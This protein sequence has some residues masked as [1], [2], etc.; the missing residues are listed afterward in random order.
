MTK[1]QIFKKA[2]KFAKEIVEEV[3][4]Y[5]IALSFALKAVY[6]EIKDS[7][8]NVNSDQFN[9]IYNKLMYSAD[10]SGAEL[11]GNAASSVVEICHKVGAYYGFESYIVIND[12][13]KEKLAKVFISEAKWDYATEH[14]YE[15]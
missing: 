3:G 6:K 10:Y 8:I 2:H 14:G 4:N 9:L 13:K 5:M 15:I 1:S 12:E 7:F 11:W